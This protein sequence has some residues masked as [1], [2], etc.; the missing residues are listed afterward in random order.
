M[1][2]AVAVIRNQKPYTAFVFFNP[3]LL[4]SIDYYCESLRGKYASDRQTVDHMLEG[5]CGEG[6]DNPR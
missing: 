4:R 3:A 6:K 1:N 2:D 5:I